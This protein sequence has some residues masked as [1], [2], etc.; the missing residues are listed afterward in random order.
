MQNLRRKKKFLVNL[1][2]ERLRSDSNCIN[3]T[4]PG[5]GTLEKAKTRKKKRKARRGKGEKKRRKKGRGGLRGEKKER[6]RER[7]AH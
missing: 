5:R 7:R 1:F 3:G 4:V 6:E 2:V